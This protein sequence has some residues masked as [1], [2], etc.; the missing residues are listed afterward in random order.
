MGCFKVER[1]AGKK[2]A[3]QKIGFLIKI[4]RLMRIRRNSVCNPEN[5]E[6]HKAWL[7]AQEEVIKKLPEPQL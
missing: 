6:A 4:R 2:Q 3:F 1:V 5:A 7:A